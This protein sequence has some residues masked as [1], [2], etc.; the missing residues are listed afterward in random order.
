M[1]AKLATAPNPFA[2]TVANPV[3]IPGERQ[4]PKDLEN[5][6]REI[7]VGG[8]WEILA[9]LFSRRYRGFGE[10]VFEKILGQ[11]LFVG[12]EVFVFETEVARFVTFG[13]RHTRLGGNI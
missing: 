8:P 13:N 12:E 4:R 9:P 5:H 2:L 1:R 11:N 10:L 3:P 7:A 6:P